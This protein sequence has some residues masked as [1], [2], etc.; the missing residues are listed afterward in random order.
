[1]REKIILGLGVI[2]IYILGLFSGLILEYC[3]YTRQ[4]GTNDKLIE[5]LQR[6]TEEQQ[7]E[8]ERTINDLTTEIGN[9]KSNSAEAKRI[10]DSMG[11]QLG[12]DS[13]DIKRAADLIKTLRAQI[14]DLQNLYSCSNNRVES[15]NMEV[16]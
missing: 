10:V 15:D 5:Q 1:M 7:R 13:S 16:K 3:L 2:L 11:V 12:N 4:P 6:T 9:L 8:A 14:M